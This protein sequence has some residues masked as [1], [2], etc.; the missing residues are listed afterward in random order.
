MEQRPPSQ[1][2][3]L[4]ESATPRDFTVGMRVRLRSRVECVYGF[5]ASSNTTR[6]YLLT[7]RSY[8]TNCTAVFLHDKHICS[9]LALEAL[10]GLV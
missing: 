8:P 5:I 10:I 6:I 3:R 9:Q 7:F 4:E 2:T 1:S